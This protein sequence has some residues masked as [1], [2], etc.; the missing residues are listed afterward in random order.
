MKIYKLTGIII[1][2]Y[3]YSKKLSNKY[4]MCSIPHE[5]IPATKPFFPSS[6]SF[7]PCSSVKSDSIKISAHFITNQYCQILNDW[8]RLITQSAEQT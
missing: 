3:I 4:V 5:E 6:P 2:P 8:H 7:L 1:T